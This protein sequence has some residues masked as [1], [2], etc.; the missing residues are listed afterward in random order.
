M[1]SKVGLNKCSRGGRLL[2]GLLILFSLPGSAHAAVWRVDVDN[3]AG[4]WDGT[5][6]PTAFQT[7][8][9]GVHAAVAEWL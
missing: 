1:F 6:W 9:E 5:S 4:P 7:I 3:S 8:Q 2:S